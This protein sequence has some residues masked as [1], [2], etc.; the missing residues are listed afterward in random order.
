MGVRELLQEA[1]ANANQDRFAKHGVVQTYES[2][3]VQLKASLRQAETVRLGMVSVRDAAHR[4]YR[5]LLDYCNNLELGQRSSLSPELERL[6]QE[7]NRATRNL[8]QADDALRQTQRYLTE[9][10]RDCAVAQ[11]NLTVATERWEQI[12]KQLD[13]AGMQL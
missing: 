1:L 7:L 12:R 10:E 6:S 2:Q 11:S 8:T 13:R 3:L 4:N 5:E 9:L